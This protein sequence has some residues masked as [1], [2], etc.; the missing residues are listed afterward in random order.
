MI[1]K[2]PDSDYETLLTEAQNEQIYPLQ[3]ALAFIAVKTEDEV[4]MSASL[5]FRF[6]Y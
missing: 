2:E 5:Q 1:K 4:R 3:A 6:L